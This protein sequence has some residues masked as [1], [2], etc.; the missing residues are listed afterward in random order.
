MF[1]QCWVHRFASACSRLTKDYSSHICEEWAQG[2]NEWDGIWISYLNTL[3]VLLIEMNTWVSLEDPEDSSLKKISGHCL[4]HGSSHKSKVDYYYFFSCI[5]LQ[6]I[7]IDNFSTLLFG[8]DSCFNLA[9]SVAT[10][11]SSRSKP[12]K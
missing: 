10:L 7:L 5:Y 11:S 9:T 2:W 8:S 1:A 3:C 12:L 6:N 4:R